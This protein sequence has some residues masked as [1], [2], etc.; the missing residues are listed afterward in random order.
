M[1]PWQ[2]VEAA[3]VIPVLVF[4]V[5]LIPMIVESQYDLIP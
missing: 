3:L 2:K 1:T 5:I 4:A